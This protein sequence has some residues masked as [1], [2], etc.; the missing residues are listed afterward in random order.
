MFQVLGGRILGAELF[1][2]IS[3]LWT[4]MF[5]TFTVGLTPIEQYVARESTAGNRVLTRRSSAIVVVVLLTT[6]VAGSFTALTLD[7][8]FLGITGF[9]W[10]SILMVLT[11]APVFISRGLAVGQRRFDH[12]GISLAVEGLGRL[13][14][15]GLGLIVVGGP[16]GVA[17]GVAFGPVF[18]LFVPS[19]GFDRRAKNPTARG[20]GAFLAPYI[21]ASA[22]SQVMLAGAPLAVAALGATPVVISIIFGTISLFRL[23]VTIVFLLQARLLNLLVRLKIAGDEPRLT[24]VRRRIEIFGAATVVMGVVAGWVL[25]P[26]F[27]ALVFGESFRP[28]PLIAALI[29]TGMAGAMSAQLLG[30]LLVADGRTARLARRWT[31]G[32]LIAV[33][34]ALISEVVLGLEP[35]ITVSAAFAAGE[36]AAALAMARHSASD[37]IARVRSGDEVPKET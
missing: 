25:G 9:T 5:L 3:V 10:V 7:R 13:V 24:R 26:G 34:T 28:D 30:Q 36:L 11:M 21:G 16:I 15:A 20:A 14:F 18:S 17:W 12:Y 8:F 23:P 29:A 1:A 6:I 22:A 19:Y 35:A 32:L 4:L 2:P 37:P 33:V 31:F 27:V